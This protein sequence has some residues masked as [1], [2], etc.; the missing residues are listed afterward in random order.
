[1]KS[2]VR[3]TLMLGTAVLSAGC[4]GSQSPIG[5]PGA[6]PQRAYSS[7]SSLYQVLHRF[8]PHRGRR[9]YWGAR[10]AAGFIDVGGML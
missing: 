9:A 1:M 5:A 6:M 8:S 2:F 4:G 10:P 7:S 3:F